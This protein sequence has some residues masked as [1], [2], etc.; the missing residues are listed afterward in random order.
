[1]ADLPANPRPAPQVIRIPPPADDTG[2][3][4]AVVGIVSAL[5]IGAVLLVV[6]LRSTPGGVIPLVPLAVSVVLLVIAWRRVAARR[7]APPR[8]RSAVPTP[9]T[10]PLVRQLQSQWRKLS[11]PKLRLRVLQA[12]LDPPGSPRPTAA[13]VICPDT[14]P[15]PAVG[16]LRFEPYIITAT[17]YLWRQLAWVPFLAALF[18]AWALQRTAII[19]VLHLDPG[20]FFYLILMGVGVFVTWA[21]KTGIRP[22]YVRMAPGIIQVMEYRLGRGKPAIRSYPMEAGTFVVVPEHSKWPTV[23]LL[24][25]NQR[26]VLPIAQMR[27]RAEV[28]ERLWQS[29]LSTAPIPKLSDEDLVG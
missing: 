9:E 2:N 1:M 18:A 20:D 8:L 21:W 27:H 6:S 5:G 14:L 19:S 15:V 22:T 26:D 3:A 12:I 11:G 10:A 28:A 23:T 25:G 24:R 7:A 16:D 17:Q 4:W 13:R 29:L